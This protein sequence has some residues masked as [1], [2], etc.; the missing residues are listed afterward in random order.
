[1]KPVWLLLWIIPVLSAQVVPGKYIVE[2]AGPP[3]TSLLARGRVRSE[4][5]RVRPALESLGATVRSSLDLVANAFIVEIP[6]DAAPRLA[7]HPGVVRVTPVP[8]MRASLD[9]ALP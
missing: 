8:L 2:L 9:H 6:D 7:R 4:Q 3:A 5:A 1:M